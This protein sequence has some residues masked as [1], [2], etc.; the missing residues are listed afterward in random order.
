MRVDGL[1]LREGTKL[2]NLTCPS[3][4]EF[5]TEVTDG[6]L[7]RLKGHASLPDGLYSFENAAWEL[8]AKVEPMV[9]VGTTYELDVNTG[10][11]VPI[12]WN[13]TYIISNSTF[14]V[15]GSKVRVKRSGNYEVYYSI[16]VESI[17]K[18]RAKTIGI[19]VRL[20]S[21][22]VFNRSRSYQFAADSTENDK[23]STSVKFTTPLYVGDEL[24]LCGLRNGADGQ[25]FTIA[26]NCTFGIRRLGQI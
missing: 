10:T 22:Y 14:E 1:K 23:A 5:P 24:E 16:S 3:G 13:R 21:G 8:I 12:T 7:F 9:E 26:D 20:S 15:I 17:T 19:F 18:N 25:A 6:E 2:D 11:S 4:N